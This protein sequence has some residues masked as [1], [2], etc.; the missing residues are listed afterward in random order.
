MS[1]SLRRD[2]SNMTSERA[3]SFPVA[4]MPTVLHMLVPPKTAQSCCSEPYHCWPSFSFHFPSLA[5]ALSALSRD[6]DTRALRRETGG[7][8]SW[9]NK[10]ANPHLAVMGPSWTRVPS[11]AFGEASPRFSP[12]RNFHPARAHKA[13]LKTDPSHF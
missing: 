3:R 9:L 4:A 11:H 7:S 13:C 5:L 1:L 6:S 2:D 10:N 8:F 12:L